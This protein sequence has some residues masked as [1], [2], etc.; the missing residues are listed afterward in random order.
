MFIIVITLEVFFVRLVGLGHF[1]SRRR[2]KEFC[3]YIS[4]YGLVYGRFSSSDYI[5]P[6]VVVLSN[7]LETIV[8]NFTCYPCICQNNW[9]TRDSNL[10]PAEHEAGILAT[11]PNLS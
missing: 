11:R 9:F 5:V 6:N 8:P 7:E 3:L 2:P 10:G 1:Y 4:I